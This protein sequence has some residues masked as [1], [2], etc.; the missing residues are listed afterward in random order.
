[1]FFKS[2][3]K[4]K[5]NAIETIRKVDDLL[6]IF[7]FEDA[8]TILNTAMEKVIEREFDDYETRIKRK[9][10]DVYAAQAKYN[11]LVDKIKNLGE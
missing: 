6:F 5:K 10:D 9:K 2:G 4:I 11:Y 8:L 3:Y 7:A 1:M